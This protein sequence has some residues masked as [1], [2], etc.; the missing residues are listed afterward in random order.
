M[1]EI[2]SKILLVDDDR[3]VLEMLDE[4]FCDD[5]ITILASSG[6][7]AIRMAKENMDIA[8]ALMDI[9]MPGMTGIEANR[10]I[11]KFLPH[12]PVIFHTGYPG[13]YLEDEIEA[14]EK[15]FD[16]VLKGD[17]IPRLTRSVK[18]AVESHELKNDN[19]LLAR[20]AENNFGIVGKSKKMGKIY[21]LIRKL[22]NCM[23]S[24]VVLGETGTGKELVSRAIHFNS[25]R[26]DKN[27]GILNCNHK[28]SDLVESD[29]FGHKRGAF[30]DAKEDRIGLF[31][32]ANGGTV[33]LDDIGDLAMETQNK[34]LRVLDNGEFY[35]MGESILKKC[36]V[37][38]I[39]ATHR[40]LEKMVEE[41][42]FRRDLYYRLK[43]I[44]IELP[45]LRERLEDIPL[46]VNKFIQQFAIEER[47]PPKI[48]DEGAYDVLYDY[49]WPGNVRE[50]KHLVEALLS[51]TE[52]D[53]V[54][55]DDV[56]TYLRKKP[57]KERKAQTL[58]EMVDEFKRETI[59]RIL[60]KT[61]G[62]R[63]KA[64]LL[65]GMD[66]ANFH[67]LLKRLGLDDM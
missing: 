44:V 51:L 43:T 19:R 30:T 33:F 9:K 8:C 60:I 1:D 42:T 31:E 12:V 18:H 36:D 23:A 16:Y 39:C 20:Y 25:S 66:R 34:L 27:F 15:P 59:S 48:F 62:N 61:D 65:L 58:N 28:N 49:D 6:P 29:L 52:S 63:S 64:A 24:A 7:E 38:V 14:T 45:P 57:E 55:A 41:G 2:R 13:D 21:T 67:K 32:L 11:K 5:Y 53:I 46:L 35:R 47:C 10:E 50:L 3:S 4:L 26:R 17:S 56:Y 22:S 37:R 54:M 40:D